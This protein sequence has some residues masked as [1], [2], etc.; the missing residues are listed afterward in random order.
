MKFGCTEFWIEERVDG[1]KGEWVDGRTF[2]V[3]DGWLDGQLEGWTGGWTEVGRTDVVRAYGWTDF[4]L[5]GLKDGQ[6]CGWKSE[7]TDHSGNGGVDERMF[8]RTEWWKDGRLDAGDVER[9]GGW[10]TD[11]WT[12]RR[13]DGMVDGITSGRADGCMEGWLDRKTVD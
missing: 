3:T 2:R 11:G 12:E 7:R 4:Q 10:M 13:T 5:D 6:T 9:T 1:W 8:R